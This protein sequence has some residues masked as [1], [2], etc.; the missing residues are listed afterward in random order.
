M[1]YTQ[2]WCCLYSIYLLYQIFLVLIFYYFS[3]WTYSMQY[4]WKNC[5]MIL[6]FTLKSGQYERLCIILIFTPCH[7]RKNEYIKNRSWYNYGSSTYVMSSRIASSQIIKNTCTALNIL[8]SHFFT[9][10]HATLYYANKILEDSTI[11][12][13]QKHRTK[14]STN[15]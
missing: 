15:K 7:M 4:K 1:L 3:R 11:H 2:K 12:N 8:V 10:K 6:S 5:H 9:E 13:I 14:K